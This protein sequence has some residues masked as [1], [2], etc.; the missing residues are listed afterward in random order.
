MF[1]YLKKKPP[2]YIDRNARNIFIIGQSRDHAGILHQY[3]SSSFIL[4]STGAS[5][6]SSLRLAAM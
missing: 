6:Q 4:P 1:G 2:V 3:E 5:P